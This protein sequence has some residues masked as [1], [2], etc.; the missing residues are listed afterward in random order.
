M[1][2]FSFIVRSRRVLL[3][4]LAGVAM[5]MST[6]WRPMLAAEEHPRPSLLSELQAGGLIIY[7]RHSL[8]VRAGQPDNDLSNCSNQRNLTEAGRSL[9]QDIG[10]AFR[11]LQIPVGPVLSSP[12]CRCKDTAALAFGRV[13]V[14]TYLETNG[15]PRDADEQRRLD[16]LARVLREHPRAGSNTILVAHGNNLQGLALLHRYPELGIEEGAAVVFRARPGHPAEVLARLGPHEW[17]SLTTR[18]SAATSR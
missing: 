17:R 1:T 10:A 3:C 6:G 12:Y 15:D 11:E 5:L 8:T 14:A 16:E 2:K 7:F 18:R 4:V 13:E 9:A